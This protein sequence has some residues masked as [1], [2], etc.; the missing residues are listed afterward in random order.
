MRLGASLA[1]MAVF[2]A[3]VAAAW[4]AV[5]VRVGAS[6]DA[7]RARREDDASAVVS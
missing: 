2:G 3:A 6:F 4:L 1:G 7:R 5:S